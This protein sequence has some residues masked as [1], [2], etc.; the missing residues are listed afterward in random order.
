MS[1]VMLFFDQASRAP[2]KEQG[3][4]SDKAVVPEVSDKPL[5]VYFRKSIN[6]LKDR[7][8]RGDENPITN[9]F[10]VDVH[11]QRV[12]GEAKGYVVTEV[13]KIIMSGE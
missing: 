7:M 9:A 12:N 11:V 2:G 13:H 1:E 10:V 3:R 8:V 4:T 5:P 6:N